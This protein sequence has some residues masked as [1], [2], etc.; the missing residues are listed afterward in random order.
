MKKTILPL[1][2]SLL[3]LPS[4]FAQNQRYVD[5]VFT[6]FTV[7]NNVVYS[8]NN[9]VIAASNGVPYIETGTAPQ[10]P[11]LVFDLY[12]PENDTETERPLN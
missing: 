4:V 3:T 7:Q 2:L 8:V 5:E 6:N 11:A 12:E 10:A 1:F 9:S